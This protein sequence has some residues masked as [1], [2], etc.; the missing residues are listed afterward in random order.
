MIT[1]QLQRF[2]RK[3]WFRNFIYDQAIHMWRQWELIMQIHVLFLRKCYST[4]V[5]RK[6]MMAL[7]EELKN[8]SQQLVGSSETSWLYWNKSKQLQQVSCQNWHQKIK[9][10]E[11]NYYTEIMGYWHTSMQIKRMK[12]GEGKASVFL[13]KRKGRKDTLLFNKGI[14]RTTSHL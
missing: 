7:K 1:Q 4:C 6:R 13:R 11:R 9:T 5:H 8:S 2:E 14:V 12:K 3:T 10:F